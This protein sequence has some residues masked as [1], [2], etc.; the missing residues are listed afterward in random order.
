[1]GYGGSGLS[2]IFG[3]IFFLAILAGIVLFI[4]WMV[5]Q[6]GVGTKSDTAM[7]ELKLRFARG[8][9]TK[10]QFDSMKRDLS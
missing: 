2:S 9:I 5:R 8:E 4:V 10:E 1:M 6:V 7:D 3:M